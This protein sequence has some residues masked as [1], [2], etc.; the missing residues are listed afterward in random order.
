MKWKRLPKRW[1]RLTHDERREVV[2]ILRDFAERK[3][4]SL[5]SLSKVVSAASLEQM[6]KTERAFSI[7][8]DIARLAVGEVPV[9]IDDELSFVRERL[10]QLQDQFHETFKLAEKATD[11]EARLQGATEEIRQLEL[12]VK[13]L[14]ET[15]K[16]PLDAHL[17]KLPPKPPRPT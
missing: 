3:R 7:V 2:D 8:V 11:F 4:S 12:R 17:A 14:R 15:G 5:I 10:H 1:R 6:E 16:D 9:E 13:V